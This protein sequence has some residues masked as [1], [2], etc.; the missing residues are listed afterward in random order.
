MS[1]S[2]V[3]TVRSRR[4]RWAEHIDRVDKTRNVYSILVEKSFRNDCL[5]DQE[6][7]GRIT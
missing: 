2:I 1:L 3:R 7:N 4:L 5:E 6:G